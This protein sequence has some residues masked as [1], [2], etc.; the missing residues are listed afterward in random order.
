M[1]ARRP[2]IQIERTRHG[3]AVYYF[4]RIPGPRI[5]LPDAYGGREFWAAYDE[6]FKASVE[7]TKILSLKQKA[8]RAIKKALSRSRQRAK[9]KG[10]EYSIDLDWALEEMTKQKL[11]CA[12]TGIEFFSKPREASKMDPYAPSFDRIDNA[13][14][15]SKENT[16]IVIF[17]VNLMLLDWGLDVGRK[18]AGR[19]SRTQWTGAGGVKKTKVKSYG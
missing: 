4:R 12:I 11:R 14:G 6:C 10:L 9:D 5:R 13:K 19:L 1:K 2:Y 17:A 15:Y 3:R 7:S 18:I 16:R 8:E